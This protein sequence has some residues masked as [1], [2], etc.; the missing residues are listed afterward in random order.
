MVV[1]VFIWGPEKIPQI[2]KQVASARKQID[3]Y[4]KQLG[5]V[6]KEIQTSMTTGNIDNLGTV[7]STIGATGQTTQAPPEAPPGSIAAGGA[8][9]PIVDAKPIAGALAKPKPTTLSAD[10]LLIDMAKKLGISTQGK[11]RDE[12][13]NEIVQ[14][15]MSPNDPAPPPKASQ[16]EEQPRFQGTDLV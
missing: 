9:A 2:A 7:L 8:P 10:E 3:V 13:Q 14:R 11:T 5:T 6:G 4:T 1:G 15:S 16:A 12:L